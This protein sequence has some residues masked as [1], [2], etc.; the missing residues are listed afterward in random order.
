MKRIKSILPKSNRQEESAPQEAPL[1][2][3][4]PYLST[5]RERER[6][7]EKEIERER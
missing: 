3:N 5:I 1:Y 2:P 7:R 4:K 6:E